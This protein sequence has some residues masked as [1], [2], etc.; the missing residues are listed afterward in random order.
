[1]SDKLML[2]TFCNKSTFNAFE[3]LFKKNFENWCKRTEVERLKVLPYLIERGW[4]LH[5]QVPV[6]LISELSSFMDGKDYEAIDEEIFKYI[7]TEYNFE[8][9]ELPDYTLNRLNRVIENYKKDSYEEATYLGI[10]LIDEICISVYQKTFTAKRPY[11][12]KKGQ[13]QSKPDLYSDVHSFAQKFLTKF[14]SLQ[15]D[16]DISRYEDE[17]YWNRHAILHGYMKRPMGKKDSAKCL[18]TIAFLIDGKE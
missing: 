4:Y 15:V 8:E 14:S 12:P 1:M 18:M 7:P 2:D 5:S 3:F 6:T 11:K 16:V 13:D 9:G 17:N 10:P